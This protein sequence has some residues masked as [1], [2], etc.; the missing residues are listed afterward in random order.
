MV[1]ME[2]Q[3]YDTNRIIIC[4][5]LGKFSPFAVKGSDPSILMSNVEWILFDKGID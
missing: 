2:L 5:I 4:M 1:R 3:F